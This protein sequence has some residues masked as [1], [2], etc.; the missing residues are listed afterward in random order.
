[1]E[2][3]P[4]RDGRCEGEARLRFWGRGVEAPSAGSPE[5]ESDTAAFALLAAFETGSVSSAA[6][7]GIGGV[8]ILDP[9]VATSVFVAATLASFKA[10]GRMSLQAGSV[11]EEGEP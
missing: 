11:P 7:V 8:V 3:R 9:S 2:E 6:V 5:E 4:K 10:A 1:M